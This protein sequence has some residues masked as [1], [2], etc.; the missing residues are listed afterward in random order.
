MMRTSR[1]SQKSGIR[2]A[3][4]FSLL[5]LL[6]VVMI[7]GLLAALVGPRLTKGFQSSKVTTTKAQI[8]LLS[9]GVDRFF[10]DVGRYPTEDEG[11]EVLLNEPKDAP[12]WDGP[13]LERDVIPKDGWS[14]AFVY[15]TD[16]RWDFIITSLG[17]DGREGGDGDATDLTNRS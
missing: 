11:L 13:Y 7:I 4:G 15:Q 14:R 9:S 1:M 2:A 3:G 8:Q 17:A 6:I 16:E 5:E 10:A 12:E